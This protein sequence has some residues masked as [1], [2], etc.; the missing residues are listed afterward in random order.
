MHKTAIILTATASLWAGWHPLKLMT[1]YH[2]QD[3]HL[4]PGVTYVELRRSDTFTPNYGKPKTH[5][6][7]V[8]TLSRKPLSSYGAKTARAFRRLPMSAKKRY[9]IMRGGEGHLSGTSSWYY[10][11]FMLD[12]HGKMWRLETVKDL[13]DMV[14][15]I[16]TPAEA[17][18]VL[19]AHKHAEGFTT[20][21]EDYHARYRKR[22]RNYLIEEHYAVTDT[23]DG[24]CGIYTYRSTI[25]PAGRIT[26][27]KRISK[28]P[29][30]DCGAE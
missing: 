11:G 19:W 13:I 20:N 8:F 6:K 28:R 24:E 29:S 4:K 26:H 22:G 18:L 30:K 17:K 27:R 23:A 16:D 10:N 9:M 7:R 5:V 25:T 14:A 3:F 1:A 15:P 21:K 2:G 12:T